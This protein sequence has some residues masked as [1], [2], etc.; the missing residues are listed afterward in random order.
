MFKFNCLGIVPKIKKKNSL[1]LIIKDIENLQFET[2]QDSSDLFDLEF[3]S[4]LNLKYLR[5][6]EFRFE[7]KEIVI[8]ESSNN[9]YD[10][11]R[12]LNYNQLVEKC[13]KMRSLLIL[14]I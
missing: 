2:Y 5:K 6:F 7:N 12:D 13:N 4:F 10:L 9:L 3:K 8:C 11:N 1:S 14:S